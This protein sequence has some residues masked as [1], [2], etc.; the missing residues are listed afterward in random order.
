MIEFLIIICARYVMLV[1]I[2]DGN[3]SPVLVDF[4]LFKLD[5]SL[6]VLFQVLQ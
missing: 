1:H 3:E 4:D 2:Q 5:S 6:F